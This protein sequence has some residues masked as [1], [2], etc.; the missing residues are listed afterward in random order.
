MVLDEA[1]RIMRSAFLMRNSGSDRSKAWP[2][3]QKQKP[4]NRTFQN[5]TSQTE[6]K[7]DNRTVQSL[8]SRE[9]QKPDQKAMHIVVKASF[10]R[11]LRSQ[12]QT[13]SE[14]EENYH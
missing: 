8:T 14:L 3:R 13:H 10:A 9:A 6:A 1:D 5:L 12:I 11:I 7:P 4:D 2:V